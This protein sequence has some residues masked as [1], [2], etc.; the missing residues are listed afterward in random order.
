MQQSVDWIYREKLKVALLVFTVPLRLAL[1]LVVLTL[2]AGLSIA[3]TVG[4]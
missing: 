4:W 2:F 1:A 3:A